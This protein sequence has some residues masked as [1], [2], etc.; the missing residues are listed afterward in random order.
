MLHIHLLPGQYLGGPSGTVGRVPPPD[1]VDSDRWL[2]VRLSPWLW[3]AELDLMVQ[4]A[5]MAL[6]HRWS[7]WNREPS[8][9]TSRRH[10]SVWRK[11]TVTTSR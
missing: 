11:R 2:T 6:R 9:S 1:A 8:T 5:G 4:F 3:P 10:V 7:D